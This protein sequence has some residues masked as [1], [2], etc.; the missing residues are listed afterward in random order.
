VPPLRSM[1][2]VEQRLSDTH[3]YDRIGK[4]RCRSNA[5]LSVTRYSSATRRLV[6]RPTSPIG[7]TEANDWFEE[8]FRKLIEVPLVAAS[9]LSQSLTNHIATGRWSAHTC[10]SPHEGPQAARQ[11]TVSRRSPFRQDP[12]RLR[13]SSLRK[14]DHNCRPRSGLSKARMKRDRLPAYAYA[15]KETSHTSAVA[16]NAVG[17]NA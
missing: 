4:A 10:R 12:T 7:L 17:S 15:L 9:C 5:N 2:P 11:A 6:I 3:L 1:L 16:Q 8:M 14:A 13:H